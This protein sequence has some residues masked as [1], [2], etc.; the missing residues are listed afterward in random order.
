MDELPQLFN[1][2][3]GDM[4]LIGPRPERPEIAER[5]ELDLPIY[6]NRLAVRPGIT[7]L[8]QMLAPADDPKDP[9]L[10]SVRRK[11]AH[12]LYYIREINMSMD[13]RHIILHRT[14]TSPRQSAIESLCKSC[15]LKRRAKR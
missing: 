6:R 14:A 9:K 10:K 15:S 5:I 7:G 12:D 2:L 4:A 11:L 3:R 8:A 1:V 13:T